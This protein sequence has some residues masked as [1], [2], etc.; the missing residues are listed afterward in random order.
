LILLRGEKKSTGWQ[1][2]QKMMSN[3]NKFLEEV[4]NFNRENIEDWRLTALQP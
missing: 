1:T 3:P 4:K 2:A